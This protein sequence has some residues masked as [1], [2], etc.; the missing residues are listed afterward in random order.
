[1]PKRLIFARHGETPYNLEGRL[2]GWKSDVGLTANG[3]RHAKEV[4]AK[5]KDYHIDYIYASDLRRATET[6][7]IIAN[8]LTLTPLPTA[9]LRERNLGN[10]AERTWEDIQTN[11]ATDWDKFLDHFDPDWNGLAGESL[12]D[13]HARFDHFLSQLRHKHSDQTLLLVTHSGFLYTILRDYFHFFP[14]ESFLEVDHSSIT[15]LDKTGDGYSLT[16][17]NQT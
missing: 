6:A 3:R 1:M 15:I 10:F 4:A 9:G 7:T 17:F 14:T 12:R 16:A 2:M 11:S 13:M 5:L 8:A